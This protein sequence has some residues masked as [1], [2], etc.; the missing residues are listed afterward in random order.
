MQALRN[1][2]TLARLC[3]LALAW[4]AL[5]LAVAGASPF[6]KPQSIHLVCE[7]DGVARFVTQDGEEVDRALQSHTLNCVM[8]LGT[9]LP[10][11]LFA[12]AFQPHVQPQVFGFSPRESVHVANRGGPALPARGPPQGGALMAG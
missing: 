12:S 5:T 7:A 8:C 4:F 2:I 6:I 9:L 11:P 3:R 1:S 10:A